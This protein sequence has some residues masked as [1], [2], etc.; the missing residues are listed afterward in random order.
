MK[1]KKFYAIPA[2]I[3]V[4]AVLSAASFLAGIAGM[5]LLQGHWIGMTML[6]MARM[7][8][9]EN[10][11]EAANYLYR[12]G[13]TILSTLQ[14]ENN[15][16]SYGSSYDETDTIDIMN[17]SAGVDNPDKNPETTYTLAEL[18][19]FYG[20]EAYYELRAL[21]DFCDDFLPSTAVI[22]LLVAP[23]RLISH[24]TETL[25]SASSVLRRTTR[26]RR[27]RKRM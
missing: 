20:T 27:R 15:F 21:V 17:L 24:R 11:S 14:N 6:D 8:D 26:R 16:C 22:R 3:I 9:Y 10:S 1:K 2:K 25:P 13:S 23:I 4:I 7:S 18:A 5:R 12:E 19:S